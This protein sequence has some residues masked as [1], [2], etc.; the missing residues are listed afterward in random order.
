SPWWEPHCTFHGFRYGQID[1]FQYFAGSIDDIEAVAV[2]IHSDLEM[3]GNFEC[4]LPKVNQLYRNIIW[5]QRGN[6]L[7]IPMDCPQRDERLGWTGD[8][9]IFVETAC[10]NM[11]VDAFFRKWMRDL[12][13]AQH[14][15]GAGTACAPSV[16]AFGHGAAGWADALVIVPYMIYKRYENVRILEENY[17]AMKKWIDY[18]NRT[19]D[20]L[21]RPDTAFGDWLA[22]DPL[23][24]PSSLIGTAYFAFTSGLFATIAEILNQKADAVFYRNLSAN[25][26]KRFGEKFLDKNGLMRIKNQTSCTLAIAFGLLSEEETLKNGC[27]LRSLVENNGNRL[28]TGF[29]GTAYLLQALS[30]TGH[31]ETAYDLLLQEAYPSWLYSV[32]Q[33]ATTM[34][35]RWDSYS[36]ENGFGDVNMNSF[37]HYAYGAVGAWMASAVGGITCDGNKISFAL[38]PDK[39]LKYV[40]TF[41]ETPCGKASSYWHYEN[42]TVFWD[43]SAPPNTCLEVLLPVPSP[44]SVR[45]N[46]HRLQHYA[47]CRNRIKLELPCGKYRFSFCQQKT[48]VIECI[49]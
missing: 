33:G 21:L 45:I 43:I 32:N 14:E 18:Q 10:F 29:I 22:F 44:L 9:A 13:E 7:E 47:A 36:H 19:S 27:L 1:G 49:G 16:L 48:G 5:S 46:G 38:E 8:A 42:D 2:V 15:D 11:N 34:W 40:K 12:R 26:K 30:I 31:S 3:T 39:R 6:F 25:V 28:S 24:T 17:E 4:G 41:M 35:E 20:S 37:N 23:K